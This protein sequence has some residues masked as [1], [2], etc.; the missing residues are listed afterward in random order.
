[1]PS[2]TEAGSAS[3]LAG[4]SWSERSEPSFAGRP[5]S[6]KFSSSSVTV[7]SRPTAPG[8]LDS[9]LLPLLEEELEE[10]E[11]DAAEPS[12]LRA[13]GEEVPSFSG[14]SSG[15]CSGG[16]SSE[17]AGPPGSSSAA[18]N[19]AKRSRRGS[20]SSTVRRRRRCWVFSSRP[21]RVNCMVGAPALVRGVAETH[22]SSSN[23]KIST[24]QPGG[25]PVASS[26]RSV[27]PRCRTLST[28]GLDASTLREH[29]RRPSLTSASSSSSSLP[30][31]SPEEFES[32]SSLLPAL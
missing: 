2:E 15:V 30:A 18:E 21:D 6:E 9:R 16:V 11:E 7:G 17:E 12:P 4:R 14:V 13:A 24:K 28:G 22:A 8:S 1:M 3:A 27:L 10:E 29:R 20:I 31:S 19:S 32:L 5:G 26:E 25:S 23:L